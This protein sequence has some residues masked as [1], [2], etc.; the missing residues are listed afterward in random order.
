MDAFGDLWLSGVN[1]WWWLSLGVALLALEVMT[2][3]FVLLWFGAA[4]LLA[5]LVFFALPP[6][7]LDMQ[8]IAYAVL[9]MLALALGRPALLRY[10]RHEHDTGSGLNQRG[11]SL[12]G[13]QAV[14]VTPLQN[15][16]GRARAGGE[17]WSVRGAG[18]LPAGASVRVEGIEGNTLLVSAKGD[19]SA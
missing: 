14:M 10:V 16:S 1:P 12:I 15:G 8:L 4:A 17:D 19:A 7:G 11:H 5:G 2:A 6:M 9:S 13:T 18:D 3:G